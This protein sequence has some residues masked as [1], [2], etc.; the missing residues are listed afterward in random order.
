MDN[1][2]PICPVHEAP[3]DVH[4]ILATCHQ[5]SRQIAHLRRVIQGCWILFALL[6][7][8]NLWLAYRVFFTRVTGS[9]AL[10]MAVLNFALSLMNA[11]RLVRHTISNRIEARRH[12]DSCMVIAKLLGKPVV[13][14]LGP[15]DPEGALPLP[16]Y[17]RLW[18]LLQ[19]LLPKTI[20]VRL[21]T[22][23][24]EDLKA[25]YYTAYRQ[26]RSK[27]AR[28]WLRFCFALRTIILIL[29]CLWTWGLDKLLKW[30]TTLLPAPLRQW[31]T[32]R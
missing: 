29:G 31:W 5:L 19:Y 21:F 27:R 11:I 10:F 17:P 30:L 8:G 4:R 14:V 3:A 15:A 18:S 9:F 7:P 12:R 24:H 28:R 2:P 26:F 1:T 25:D 13:H 16:S 22:P 20:R 6:L 32:I 23:A